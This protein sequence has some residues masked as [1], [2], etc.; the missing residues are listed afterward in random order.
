M[1]VSSSISII[2]NKI[3][4]LV[5]PYKFESAEI[6]EQI[7]NAVRDYSRRRP[8]KKRYTFSIVSDT[9]AYPLPAGFIH[10]IYVPTEDT[11]L[12]DDGQVRLTPSGLIP[13]NTIWDLPE[14]YQIEGTQIRFIPMPKANYN[15]ETTYAAAHL[16]TG[17][18]S[19][20]AYATIPAIDE[21]LVELKAAI[22]CL[23]TL[24]AKMARENY[25]YTVAMTTEA[26]KTKQA[27]AMKAMIGLWSGQYEDRIM[28]PAGVRS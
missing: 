2:R 23:E 27:D 3:K 16:A 7:I 12:S 18:G 20:E 26:D 24:L 5:T 4:D 28:R 15:L 8:M 21:D 1:N 9:D 6:R 22:G 17:V 25:K 10:V 14:E 11:W 19:S 13:T